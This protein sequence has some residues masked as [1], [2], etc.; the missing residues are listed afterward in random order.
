M[1]NISEFKKCSECSPQK[2]GN[3]LVIKFS[4]GEL[5]YA[6]DIEYI[7]NHGW[8]VSRMSDGT[9]CDNSRIM[10]E[11]DKKAMWAEVTLSDEI[12][13]ERQES[14]KNERPILLTL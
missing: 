14:T 6:A 1:V 13:E 7:P 12:K 8:N 4:D 9:I 3:Y 2:E 10:F 5:S 11:E